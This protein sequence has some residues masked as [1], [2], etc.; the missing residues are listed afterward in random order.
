MVGDTLREERGSGFNLTNTT[1]T[2]TITG[3][4]DTYANFENVSWSAMPRQTSSMPR[5]SPARF[6]SMDAVAT[7]HCVAALA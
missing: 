1:L 3:E 7:T 2:V 5:L 6:I 4:V